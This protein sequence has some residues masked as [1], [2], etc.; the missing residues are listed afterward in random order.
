[1]SSD[2]YPSLGELLLELGELVRGQLFVKLPAVV[3]SQDPTTLRIDC[4][5][6]VRGRRKDPEDDS[7]VPVEFP[8]LQD[9]PVVYP[10]GGGFVITWPLSPGDTV[11]VEVCDR[12]I[13]E[14]RAG[15][16]L[17]AT[18]A[19][20]RR[21]SLSDAVAYPGGRR[22]TEPVSA[23]GR[24][25]GALVV[26][27]TDIRL[28][29]SAAADF[30]ALASLTNARFAAIENFLATHV[31][32][33]VSTGAGTSGTAAGAPSGASVAATRVKGE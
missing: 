9:V 3:I 4:R 30:L 23:T 27:G 32:T 33:G 15:Q 6:A 7:L 20:P 13:D 22:D 8:P 18:P 2:G 17:P 16:A 5:I 19:D 26:E 11:F 24:A 29:S 12:S 21:F 14:W 25:P 10:G 28:G 1:M 31:H